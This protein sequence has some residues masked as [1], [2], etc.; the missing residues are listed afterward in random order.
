MGAQVY[1][2]PSM[3]P[4]VLTE[5]TGIAGDGFLTVCGYSSRR[6]LCVTVWE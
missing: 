4:L 5:S 6:A 3:T 2:T 1:G